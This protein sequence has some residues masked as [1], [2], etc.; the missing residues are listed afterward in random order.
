MTVVSSFPFESASKLYALSPFHRSVW[1]WPFAVNPEP[2]IYTVVPAG[3][4]VG[5]TDRLGAAFA[6]GTSRIELQTIDQTKIL[7]GKMRH[8]LY[9]T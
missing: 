6:A 7:K 3:P 9:L 2:E 4:L 5:L 8:M 1:I